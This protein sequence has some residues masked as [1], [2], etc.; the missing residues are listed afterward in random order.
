MNAP[1]ADVAVG[2]G[3]RVAVAVAGAADERERAVDHARRGL[4]D[5]RLRGLG[6]GEERGEL[7]GAAVGVGL[8]A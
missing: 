8:A 5:E 7:L 1:G 6:L 4:V 2:A 3:E